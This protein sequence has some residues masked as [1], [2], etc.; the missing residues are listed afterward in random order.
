VYRLIFAAALAAG[1]PALATVLDKTTVVAGTQVRYKVVLPDGFDTA[2]TYP[3]ILAFG[4]GDQT[5]DIVERE[6]DSVWKQAEKR[7]YIVVIP[8]APGDDLY[9]LAGG[10][11]FPAF[12]ETILRDYKIRDGRFHAAGSSNGGISAF[13]VAAANPKYFVSITSF[14]G[15]LNNNTPDRMAAMAAMC[16]HM[17]A[18]SQDPDWVESMMAQAEQFKKRGLHV[19]TSIERG[20]PHRIA[21]LRGEGAARLFDG[22]DACPAGAK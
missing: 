15:Y 21:T 2:K 8:A 1:L 20:Q 11:I 18:G 3:G 4:G 13:A 5:M 9:F 17:Y 10:R 14:P 6:V 22:F 7:G 12:L 19:S 16:I